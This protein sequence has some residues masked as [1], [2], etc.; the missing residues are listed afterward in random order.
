MQRKVF[1]KV[2]VDGILRATGPSSPERYSSVMYKCYI[3]TI[4]LF[5]SIA[6]F[7]LLSLA[8]ENSWIFDPCLKNW[9]VGT[10]RTFFTAGWSASEC[11]PNGKHRSMKREREK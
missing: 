7:K 5:F 3:V 9:K 2:L 1:L 4:Y 11:K 6:S 8:P 10:L